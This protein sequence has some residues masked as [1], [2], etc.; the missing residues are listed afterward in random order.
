MMVGMAAFSL[1]IAVMGIFSTIENFKEQ[2]RQIAFQERMAKNGFAHTEKMG[3]ISKN[4]AMDNIASTATQQQT[5]VD[6][7]EKLNRARENRKEAED[8]LTIA[9]AETKEAKLTEKAWKSDTAVLDRYF[10]G[11]PTA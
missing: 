11:N 2:K 5:I 1:G 10:M 9:K 6:G 7:T 8:G 4:A 3:L